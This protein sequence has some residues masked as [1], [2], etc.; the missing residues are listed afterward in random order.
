MVAFSPAVGD[1]ILSFF[2][3]RPRRRFT[4]AEVLKGAGGARGDLEAI[5]EGLKQL[6]REGKLVRLKKNH[7][8]LPDAQSCVTGRVHAHPDGFGFLI[9]EEKG[10]EDIYIS[11]REMRRV[12]HGDRIL[13][14]IDR[15]KSRGSEAHVAQVLERGQKRILGTY[16]EIQGKGF[17]VPMDLRIGDRKSVV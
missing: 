9:P 10:R 15:K 4:P 11:R 14:R 12:M 16:E 3:S 2:F 17:L 13:V 6:C 5:V 1:K 8:A 7:Y